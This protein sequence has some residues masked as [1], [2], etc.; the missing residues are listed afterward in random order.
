MLRLSTYVSS[1]VLFWYREERLTPWEAFGFWLSA[2]EFLSYPRSQIW[3][4]PSE[5]LDFPCWSF[6]ERHYCVEPSQTL[7]LAWSSSQKLNSFHFHPVV[8]AF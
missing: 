6:C 2:S 7:Y 8:L 4:L 5:L 3:L 1:N